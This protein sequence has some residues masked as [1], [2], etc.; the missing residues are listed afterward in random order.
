M[1]QQHF[2][3]TK[4]EGGKLEFC[5]ILNGYE[6]IVFK[7]FILLEDHE[8]RDKLTFACVY[9]SNNNNNNII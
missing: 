9:C 4:I 6:N 2:R 7:V 3:G 5:E 8:G 1:V